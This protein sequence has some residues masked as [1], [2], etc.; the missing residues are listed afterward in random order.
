MN[1]LNTTESVQLPSKNSSEEVNIDNHPS[2]SPMSKGSS[3]TPK[4]LPPAAMDPTLPLNW[5]T[6]KKFYNMG[7][8]SLL[9]F[10]IAFGSSIYTPAVPDVMKD[11]H[12]SNT[13]AILPLTTYV[14]GLSFGPMISAP[15]SEMF[16]RLGTYKVVPPISAIFTLAAGFSPNITA[17]CLLRFFAGFFGGASL[18]VSAGTSADLFYPK[19]RAVA[20]TFM[21]YIPFLVYYVNEKLTW[22]F[23]A[24]QLA[25]SSEGS[26]RTQHHGWKWS[27][28]ALAIIIA[29]TYIPVF[30]LEET[31]LKTIL[32]KRVKKVEADV[33]T[34]NGA[35]PPASKLLLGVVFITL[36]RP[37]K[38]LFTEPIVSLLSIY[39]G[40][41]FA[42]I[43]TFFASVPYV[44]GT[45]YHFDRGIT[46]LVFL[47]V[48]LGCTFAV[49]TTIICDRLFYQKQLLKSEQ[50]GRATVVAPEYRLP[51]A[52]IGAF[53]LPV[54]LFWFA[55]SARENVHWIVP[56]IGMVPF[57]WGNLC[58]FIS[59][60]LYLIDTYAALTAASAVA[61]NTLLRYILGATF[62]LFTVSMYRQ[63]GIGWA[64]SLLG[65]LSLPM[66]PIPWVFYKWGPEIRA[67]SGFE[68]NKNPS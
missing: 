12:V 55:W 64:T 18:P 27:Q 67:A 14:L 24:P 15:I 48:G 46:G 28:Y 37:T 30:F 16:G 40:F 53:G 63:L 54:G 17:L 21:L 20:G 47:A 22:G 52:M 66:V 6:L 29:V 4:E 61:A 60:C 50:E 45:V 3:D 65:F 41:N 51:A 2:G 11:F 44:F 39:V 5:S 59:A 43:F 8:P 35:K 42:V 38:M 10:V 25:R 7:V 57:A 33:E 34:T 62:P 9:C 56:I 58:I 31:Y 13:V 36:L 23:Q 49:P 68:T 19:D 1:N 32:S 26:L